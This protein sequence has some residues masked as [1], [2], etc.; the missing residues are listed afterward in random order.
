VAVEDTR[1][2][3]TGICPRCPYPEPR[4]LYLL[5]GR[6]DGPSGVVRLCLTCIS[7][8]LGYPVRPVTTGNGVTLIRLGPGELP[9]PLGPTYPQQ[10]KGDK[11]L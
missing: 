11:N 5:D 3:V 10:V 6:S 7:T 8:R 4:Y 1:P 9:Y 2:V